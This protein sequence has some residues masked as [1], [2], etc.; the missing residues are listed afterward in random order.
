[1]IR[2]VM[3]PHTEP[4][5]LNILPDEVLQHILFFLSPRDILWNILRVSKRFSQLGMR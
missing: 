3:S 4:V 1:M 5:A 2:D